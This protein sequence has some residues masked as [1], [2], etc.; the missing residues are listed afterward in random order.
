MRVNWRG[1]HPGA[2]VAID[3]I[4]WLGLLVSAILELLLSFNN[5]LS[6][7]ASGTEFA[8]WFVF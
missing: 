8:S 3:L 1:I 5:E 4:L 7:A 6:V 2:L